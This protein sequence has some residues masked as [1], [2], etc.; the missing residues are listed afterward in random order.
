MLLGHF[1]L[2]SYETCAIPYLIYFKQ[3]IAKGST[4]GFWLHG[5]VG[6]KLLGINTAQFRGSMFNGFLNETPVD[7]I[8]YTIPVNDDDD[9]MDILV[10]ATDDTIMKN[11]R[12]IEI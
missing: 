7:N 11:N 6:Y 10:T 1:L 2:L 9:T 8:P 12:N 4:V 5:R 3:D